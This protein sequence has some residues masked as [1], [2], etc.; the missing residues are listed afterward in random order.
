MATPQP[1]SPPCGERA[2]TPSQAL[3]APGATAAR[4]RPPPFKAAP[5]GERL[6]SPT[7][8]ISQIPEQSQGG[9]S[10]PLG[11]EDNIEAFH[12]RSRPPAWLDTA[13][14]AAHPS[15]APRR[16]LSLP[17]S[18]GARIAP[19]NAGPGML[20]EHPLPVGGT[21]DAGPQDHQSGCHGEP[22]AW[23]RNTGIGRAGAAERRCGPRFGRPGAGWGSLLGARWPPE[24]GRA[25]SCRQRRLQE[26]QLSA[27]PEA[28][29]P[30][31]QIFPVIP[32]LVRLLL[33]ADPP[34]QLRREGAR[35][36]LPPAC[37]RPCRELRRGHRSTSSP[38]PSP[39][40][41]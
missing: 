15:P 24:M 27:E 41:N 20:W 9:K 16:P 29:K 40:F 30:S 12:H 1:R 3:M 17:A 14:M 39:C 8:G 10:F 18:S 36:V 34:I 33:P 19:Q 38:G 32:A 31:L 5:S 23:D 6:T 35:H 25:N 13:L 28:K 37:A 2:N 22:S 4:L 11:T 7:H 26:A 21:G